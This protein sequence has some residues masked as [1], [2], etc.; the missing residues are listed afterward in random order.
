[1]PIYSR[2]LSSGSSSKQVGKGCKK[3]FLPQESD[4]LLPTGH[5][6]LDFHQFEKGA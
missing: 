1:V 6:Q 4:H 2:S 5:L 3:V